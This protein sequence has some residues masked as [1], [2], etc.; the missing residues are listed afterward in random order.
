MKTS[1]FQVL[2]LSC[3]ISCTPNDK[4]EETAAGKPRTIIREL[5]ANELPTGEKVIASSEHSLLTEMVVSLLS[6]SCIIVR[7]NKFES[8]GRKDE[9]SIPSGLK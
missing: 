4:N 5:N 7:N 1:L 9:I 6:S 3:L 8:V 2:C